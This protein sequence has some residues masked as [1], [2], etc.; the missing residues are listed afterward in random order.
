MNEQELARTEAVF[1]EVNEA[2]A[3]TAERYD[4]PDA[5]FIC[6]CGD[7][8]CG[9]RVHVTLADYER[10]RS[11]GASFIVADAHAIKGVEKI[12]RRKGDYSVIKKVGKT[13]AEVARRLNPRRPLPPQPSE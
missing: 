12:V 13:V 8:D 1:R 10:V 2:I 6:E 4:E 7:P 3:R 9:E 11:D 5:E